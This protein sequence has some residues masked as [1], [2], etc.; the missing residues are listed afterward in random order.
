MQVVFSCPKCEQTVRATKGLAEGRRR[1]PTCG[2]ERTVPESAWQEGRLCQCLGCGEEDLWRQKDFP[3]ALG[4]A[5]VGLGILLSTIAWAQYRPLMAIGVLMLF[6]LV[7][8]ALYS[9]MKDVLVCY[10]CHARHRLDTPVTGHD[11]FNHETA[12]RFRQD[13]IRR[14]EHSAATVTAPPR[15]TTTSSPPL[16][17][18]DREPSS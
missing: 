7:D 3:Q 14:T 2:D 1:C 9:L 11:R 16:D 15:D 5:I 12:E 17:S 18:D 8:L 4:L 13:V 6:A 10:R